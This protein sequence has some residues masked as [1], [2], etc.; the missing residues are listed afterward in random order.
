MISLGKTYILGDSYSTYEGYIPDGYLYYYGDNEEN[1]VNNVNLTWWYQLIDETKS[2]LIKNNSYSGSTVCNIGY[3]GNYCPESSFSGRLDKDINEG[4]FKENS[5]DTVLFMGGTNDTWAKSPVGE[6]KYSDW[7]EEDLK[8]TLP[9][10]C[11]VVD[12]LKKNAD[13]A[14]IIFIIN[15]EL[16]KEIADGYTEACKKYG[17]EY[18]PLKPFSKNGGHPNKQGMK[19][20]KNQIIEYLKNKNAVS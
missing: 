12:K 8:S 10:F 3:N 2:E 11:Y 14:R 6:L 4:F 7:D 5:L 20:I 9:A 17:I 1:D 15:I 13:G 16:S 19:E 18:L